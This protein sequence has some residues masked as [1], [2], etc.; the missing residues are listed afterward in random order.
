M[1]K[2]ALA[3]ID[4]IKNSERT[5]P[6]FP[7]TAFVMPNATSELPTFPVCNSNCGHGEHQLVGPVS[8]TPAPTDILV[9]ADLFPCILTGNK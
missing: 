5:P 3:L 7:L 2:T 9:G 1:C 8:A 6:Q 4:T